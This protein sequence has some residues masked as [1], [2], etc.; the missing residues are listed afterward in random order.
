MQRLHAPAVLD[1]RR[2]KPVE[3]LGMTRAIAAQ[4]EVVRRFHEA[5]AEVV[6]PDAVHDYARGEWIARI[7][8][9]ARELGT[10]A[11]DV[12]RQLGQR[13]RDEHLGRTRAD[14]FA[15]VL[16]HAAL[17]QMDRRAFLRVV[18]SRGNRG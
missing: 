1:E 16:P 12:G 3:Q 14:G 9:P 7:G 15:L 6:L 13:V 18:P 4:T 8:D 5:R 2:R 10:R 11:G 17:E